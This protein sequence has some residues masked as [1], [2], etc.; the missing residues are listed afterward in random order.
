ML[1]PRGWW[2]LAVVMATL[3]VAVSLGAG[4][5][6]LISATL[7]LW[8]LAVWAHFT[9]LTRAVPWRLA[10]RREL[11]TAAGPAHVIWARQTASVV[12]ELTW[13]GGA[14]LP[15]VQAVDRVP[16]LVGT[17]EGEPWVTGPLVRGVPLTLEYRVRCPAAGGLRFDGLKVT[18]TDLQGFFYRTAF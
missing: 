2:F 8:F 6:V 18:V 15:F 9:W 4:S 3:L 12:A 14:P 13:D 11:R 5:L 7:L 10:V 1:T 16:E 17:P